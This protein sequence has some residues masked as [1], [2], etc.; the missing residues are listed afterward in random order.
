MGH[1]GFKDLQEAPPSVASL[2]PAELSINVSRQTW[3]FALPPKK[4]FRTLLR[5]FTA[6]SL[7]VNHVYITETL[8]KETIASQEKLCYIQDKVTVYF[9]NKLKL[10]DLE[11]KSRALLKANLRQQYLVVDMT[12]DRS[13]VRCCK[14]QY[15]IGTWNVR[16]MNQG[17]LEVVKQEMARVNVDILGI[18]ELKWTGMGEFNS[19]DHYIYYCG[20]E[21]LRRNGVAIMVNKRVRNAVLGCNLK[22]DRMISFRFQGKPFNITVIQAYAPTS[23]AEEAEVNWFYE[24]LQDLLELTPKKDVLFIIGDWN[25]KVGSQ[26]TPGV[27]GKFGLGAR[28]EA[29]QRLIEFCQENALVIANTLFQQHKRRLYTWTSPDGQHRNQIDYILCNQRWRSCIQLAKT[30]PG[31]DCGSDHELLI[32]KFRLKLKK[33][34]KTTRP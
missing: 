15:C 34:G 3:V 13:K 30:R 31:A 17:K 14:E 26:E 8:G 21:S 28:N 20:Q 33:V 2:G 11:M 19:D 4:D 16:S 29:G 18:S 24:D 9:K 7:S 27:T 32:A 25:A 10:K 5:L 23:N 12:S 22:N 1:G 6:L